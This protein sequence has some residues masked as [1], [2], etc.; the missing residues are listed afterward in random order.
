MVV[1]L[2][3]IQH[4]QLIFRPSDRD[5]EQ[6]PFFFQD[7]FV[8]PASNRGKLPIQEPD[9]KD[10]LPLQSLRAVDGGEGEVAVLLVPAP[11]FALIGI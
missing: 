10:H 3:G 11:I 4:R 7:G 1:V 9:D 6:A 5:I 2:D 8:V